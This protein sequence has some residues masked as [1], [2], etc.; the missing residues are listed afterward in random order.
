VKGVLNAFQRSMLRWR[1]LHPYNAV[2]AVALEREAPAHAVA[3]AIAVEL[4]RCGLTGL[5]VDRRR[6]RYEYRGG[7]AHVALSRVEGARMLDALEPE[8]ERQLNTPFGDAE[9]LDPFRFFLVVAADGVML[10]LAY[11]H[12]VAAGDCIIALLHAIAGRIEGI[13]PSTPRPLLYPPAHGWLFA[14]N[15][16][17]LVGGL[18][19]LPSLVRNARSTARPRY[20]DPRD[21]YNGY[22]L[23]QMPASQ[24]DVLV[25]RTREWGVTLNDALLALLLDV[26]GPLDPKRRSA[27]RRRA[28]AVASIMNLRGEFGDAGASAFGQFLG[29]LTV[30]HPV[31]A[32]IDLAAL[33]RDVH[34]ETVRVKREKLYLQTLLAMRYVAAVWPMLSA[35]QRARFYAKTYPIWAGLST[36]NVNAL[37]P[38]ANDAVPPPVYI[39]GVPTG[40]LAPLV[41]A[42]T[43]VGNTLYAGVSFRTAAFTRDDIDNLW[44]GLT[45]RLTALT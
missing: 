41:V 45:R 3:A 31:P 7:P 32:G 40:P 39:R 38:R 28:L 44:T 15:L 11:D 10:G 43:T 17:H 16:A 22:R 6:G 37:W 35:E 4:E 9:A 26:L 20:R 13:E 42:T 34:A 30:S 27:K 1:E 18:A 12:F 23:Y 33:A 5:R 8:I 25:R 24:Y 36:L 2:H 14:R 19:R 21:G 29:S